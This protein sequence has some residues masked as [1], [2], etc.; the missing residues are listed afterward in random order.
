MKKLEEIDIQPTPWT[1]EDYGCVVD[2]NGEYVND[3][4]PGM[5]RSDPTARL[6][7]AAPELYDAAE[8][9]IRY[10]DMSCVE[11]DNAFREVIKEYQTALADLRKALAKA[12][13]EEKAK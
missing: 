10:H 1:V 12:A 13:G 8:R 3:Y 9:V 2:D 6:V 11:Y 7:A 5:D 4:T